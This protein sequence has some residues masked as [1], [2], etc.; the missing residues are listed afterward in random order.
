MDIIWHGNSCFTIKTKNCTVVID[1]YSPSIGI[2]PPALK[3]DLVLTSRNH[4]GHNN[5][6]AVQGEPKIIDWPGEY[7]VKGFTVNAQKI[8]PEA[9]GKNV[10]FFNLDADGI[11]ICFL[12]DVGKGLNDELIEKIGSM[13]ILLI[14]VGGNDVMD[15]KTAHAVVEELEPRTVIPMHF[16]VP[17]LKEKYDG[18]EPFLKISGAVS[19]AKDKFTVGSKSDLPAEKTDILY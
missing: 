17:G 18:V 7:E 10:M 14:P 9:E 1:P 8:E 15:A 12:G 11:K 16:A 6:A 19:E 5:V 13:D 3:A 4:P 2:K